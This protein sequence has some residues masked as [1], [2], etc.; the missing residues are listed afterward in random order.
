MY[1]PSSVA[2]G[3]GVDETLFVL[4]TDCSKLVS[5]KL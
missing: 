1:I 4:A 5:H 2:E 3:P